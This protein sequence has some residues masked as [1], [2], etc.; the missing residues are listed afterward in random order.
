MPPMCMTTLCVFLIF[1][2][3]HCIKEKFKFICSIFS[4]TNSQ[5]SSHHSKILNSSKED[6]INLVNLLK[7]IFGN[8][9]FVDV[10]GKHLLFTNVDG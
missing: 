3:I 10:D 9:F 6:I 5:I 8:S 4:A 2:D 1:V 7:A